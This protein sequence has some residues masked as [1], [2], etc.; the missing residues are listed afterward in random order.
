[1]SACGRDKHSTY[2]CNPVIF[3]SIIRQRTGR[4]HIKAKVQ[5]RSRISN[6]NCHDRL[7]RTR[8][9]VQWRN[10]TPK[11][12][13]VK[14]CTPKFK[15]AWP[16]WFKF[17]KKNHRELILESLST[18]IYCL[19]RLLTLLCACVCTCI[20]VCMHAFARVRACMH[21]LHYTVTSLVWG[22]RVSFGSKTP[23][24][25]SCY[26]RSLSTGNLRRC[27]AIQPCARPTSS[28]DCHW[29]WHFVTPKTHHTA[30]GAPACWP[31][32]SCRRFVEH[33]KT[34]A[35]GI[36][37]K[38]KKR[39]EK[40]R[41]SNHPE[42][43]PR[44]HEREVFWIFFIGL[45]QN[46]YSDQCLLTRN[47][48]M[49]SG[50]HSMTGLN[51]LSLKQQ[52]HDNQWFLAAILCGKNGGHK[53]R[54]R[55]STIA[56]RKRHFLDSA[57]VVKLFTRLTEMSR[58]DFRDTCVSSRHFSSRKIKRKKLLNTATLPL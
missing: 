46:T 10:L 9:L 26:T 44:V 51:H 1:M 42:K 11:E 48:Q 12:L 53:A 3:V 30:R 56:R 57:W 35:P 38:R 18:A 16:S 34:Q 47:K 37:R 24:T 43:R 8:V 4:D 21:V 20:Y 22:A 14:A 29:W 31:H 41:I 45:F 19:G 39:K 15:P 7:N 23:L 52:C 54:P 33:Q 27:H 32:R 17:E 13:D 6:N 28:P 40:L 25:C 58:S 5:D 55:K 49:Q 50:H 2:S 36:Q